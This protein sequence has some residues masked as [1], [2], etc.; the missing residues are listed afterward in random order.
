MRRPVTV[1]PTNTS[2]PSRGRRSRAAA[3]NR[4]RFGSFTGL[5]EP[6]AQ[7]FLGDFSVPDASIPQGV[8]EGQVR[9]KG[10]VPQGSDGGGFV[11][12][13][14][15]DTALLALLVRPD[16]NRLAALRDHPA[17][18][19]GGIRRRD[20]AGEFSPFGRK[21]ILQAAEEEFFERAEV[22]AVLQSRAVEQ[23][24]GLSALHGSMHLGRAHHQVG[25][26]LGVRR[27]ARPGCHNLERDV[28]VLGLQH[29]HIHSTFA[30]RE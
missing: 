17:Q 23:M 10:R 4:L 6:A 11:Q 12:R 18:R 13:L 14:K 7:L 24:A 8:G 28:N 15:R 19:R 27:T 21:Y 25:G 16:G 2:S 20:P 22:R 1:P 3:I 9:V 5:P 29:H 26:K 30:N